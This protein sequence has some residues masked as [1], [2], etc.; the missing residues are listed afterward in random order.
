[1]TIVK[2]TAEPQSIIAASTVVVFRNA[3]A[4]PPEL[5]M[6]RRS[7]NLSF[8]ASAAVF[9]GGKI[10]PSD[11]ALADGDE[12]QAARIA[13]VRETLEETGL[14][15]GVKEVVSAEQAAQA[16]SMLLANEDLAPV[17]GRF[18]WTLDTSQLVAFARW[19]PNFKPGRIFDTRF[20]LANIGTG[21][22]ALTPDQGENVQVLWISA[23]DAL[24]A[25]ETGDLKAIY[26]TRRN[27]ERL[28]LFETYEDIRAHALAT[29]IRTVSPWIEESDQG[30]FLHIAE[31]MGYPVTR[32]PL[33][34]IRVE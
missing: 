30:E 24:S 19:L 21:A 26:P 16:R 13:A 5:L 18:G 15:L 31:G 23:A 11:I 17:L 6:V 9:P 28:A 29:P 34:Q 1:V 25:V 14:V 3:Q 22:V 32:A 4:G 27:L 7:K 2:D 12:E 8:A 20:Y 33:S 10:G